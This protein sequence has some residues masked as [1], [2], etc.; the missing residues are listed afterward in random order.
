KTQIK[1]LKSDVIYSL[2]VTSLKGAMKKNAVPNALLSSPEVKQEPFFS[3]EENQSF[4][5]M[6]FANQNQTSDNATWSFPTFQPSTANT[7]LPTANGQQSPLTAHLSSNHLLLNIEN[8]Y[9]I[10]D[11]KKL[12][13]AYI[14]SS[15]IEFKEKEE[16]AG[17]LLI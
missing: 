14:V 15:L 4:D 10:A 8:N 7:Q 5:L 16:T 9:Y 12:M 3:R 11:T 13:S 6:N 1:F 17:P 2:L